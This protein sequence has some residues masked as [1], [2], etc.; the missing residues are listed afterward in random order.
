MIS[1]MDKMGLLL[2]RF[3]LAL[4]FVFSGVGKIVHFGD[5]AVGMAGAGIPTCQGGFGVHHPD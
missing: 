5:T 3:L 1:T 4:I 2:G